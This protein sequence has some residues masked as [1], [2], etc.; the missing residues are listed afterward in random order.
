M[1]ARTRNTA[2]AAFAIALL[3]LAAYWYWSPFLALKQIQSAARAQDADA[4]NRHV[5]Y[6]R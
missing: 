6:P 5:D 4:F 2:L 3:A 1:L